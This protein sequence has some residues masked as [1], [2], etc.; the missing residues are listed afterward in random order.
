[1]GTMS[2]SALVDPV[3]PRVLHSSCRPRQSFSPRVFQYSSLSVR[4]GVHTRAGG[5]GQPEAKVVRL[6]QTTR[7][8]VVL[9]ST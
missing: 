7:L 4:P 9:A 2:L 1:M 6:P 8:Q 5:K 3:S